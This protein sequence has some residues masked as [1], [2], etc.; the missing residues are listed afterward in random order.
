MNWD[1]LGAI[2]ETIGAIAVI[3]TLAYLAVQIR[4][5]TRA[6]QTAS[7]HAITDSLN[8]GNIAMAQD[9]ELCQIWGNRLCGS[10]DSDRGRART[11]G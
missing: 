9:A 11:F 6:T 3:V 8:L 4:Q 2:S 5:N 1:A 7:H 10:S